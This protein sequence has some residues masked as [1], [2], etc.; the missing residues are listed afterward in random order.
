MIKILAGIFVLGVVIAIEFTFGDRKKLVPAQQMKGGFLERTN[1]V[2]G[3][4]AIE[5]KFIPLVQRAREYFPTLHV[6]GQFIHDGTGYAIF[7]TDGIKRSCWQAKSTIEVD[8]KKHSIDVFLSDDIEAETTAALVSVAK[9]FGL[10]AR[11]GVEG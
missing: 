11:N 2:K 1:E 9:S 8:G 3:D 5:S 7:F 6:W 10:E 4:P